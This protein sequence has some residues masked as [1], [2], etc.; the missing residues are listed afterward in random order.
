MTVENESGK[1]K[2]SEKPLTFKKQ[3]WEDKRWKKRFHIK[4]E[5]GKVK[6]ERNDI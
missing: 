1:E 4:S 2:N 3:K 5:S 6:A